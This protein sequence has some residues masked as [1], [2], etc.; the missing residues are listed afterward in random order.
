[1]KCPPNVNEIYGLVAEKNNSIKIGEDLG[2]DLKNP[3]HAEIWK[4][5]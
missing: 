4:V 1:M 5:D 2:Q 3:G